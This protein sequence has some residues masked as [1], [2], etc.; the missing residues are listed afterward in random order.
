VLATF[1]C[2]TDTTLPTILHL[3]ETAWALP[4]LMGSMALL[5]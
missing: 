3:L 1:R 2:P 5:H 4:F